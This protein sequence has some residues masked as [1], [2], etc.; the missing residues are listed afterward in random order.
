MTETKTTHS[1]TDRD[2]ATT[3]GDDRPVLESRRRRLTAY[4]RHNGERICRD[5]AVLTTWALLMTIWVQGYGL[6]RWLCYVVTFVGVVG[7]THVTSPW[8]RPYVSPEER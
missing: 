7:Y 3:V 5:A 6:P 2:A 4:L 8:S 1:R